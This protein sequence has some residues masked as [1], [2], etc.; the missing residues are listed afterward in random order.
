MT[1][2]DSARLWV[3]ANITELEG[4]QFLHY[5]FVAVKI[6]GKHLIRESALD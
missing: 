2:L 1:H 6:L 3:L 4:D 5:L